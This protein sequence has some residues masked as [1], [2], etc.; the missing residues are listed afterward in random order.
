MKYTIAVIGEGGREAA[1]VMAYSKSR[2]VEK[3]IAIPGNDLM[4]INSS[5]PVVIFPTVATTDVREI[6]RICRKEKV[7]LI[8]VAQDDAVASGVADSLLKENFYVV[9][10]TKKAGKIEWSK[11]F[12]RQLMKKLNIPQPKFKVFSSTERGIEYLKKQD[13][14]PWFVKADGLTRGKGALPAENNREA[15]VRIKELSKFEGAGK[16][17][18]L[19]KWI[20]NNNEIAEEF[21][22]F[23]IS[24]G[25]IFQLIGFAQDHKRIFDGDKGENTGGIGAS[26]PPLLIDENIKKQVNN[27][28]KKT[29]LGLKNLGQSYKGV[30]YLGGILIGEKV[31]A[32]EFNA[33]WGDPEAEV[34]V[35]SILNDM[36]EIGMSVAKAELKTINIKLDGYRRVAVTGMLKPGVSNK[37]RELFGIDKVLKMKNV[38]VYGA[39]VTHEENKYFVSSEGRWFHIVGKGKNV[40]EARKRAYE[41][42]HLLS[43]E[44]NVLHFRTDIGWRDVKRMNENK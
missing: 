19:E 33:R 9:G 29:F 22:A 40:I 26:A 23:A 20:K 36:F 39:R 32:I 41:A 7:G 17:Y 2:H 18:L 8:D 34:L 3:I 11:A 15:V 28:F 27:I 10:P 30:L 1:L 25:K 13:D 35:P 12:S 44:E 38:V 4:Q 5:K 31:Y 16:K 43:I 21:S 24:D 14:Q 42:I 6:V 37:K